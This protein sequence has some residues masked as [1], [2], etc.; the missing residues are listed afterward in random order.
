MKRFY[1]I[2]TGRNVFINTVL[3]VVLVL[4]LSITVHAEEKPSWAYNAKSYVYQNGIGGLTRVF[5]DNVHYNENPVIYV[6]EYDGSFTL[7][8]KR[9]IPRELPL[10]GGFYAGAEYNYLFFGQTNK[11]ED[12]NAEVIRVVKYSKS[13]ERLGHASVLGANTTEPFRSGS[14]RC[15]EAGGMLY[16]HTC[17]QMYKSNDGLNH[18]ANMTF[19]VRVGDMAV[20]SVRAGISYANTGYV[21]HSFDQYILADKEGNIVTLDLGDAYPRAITL[22][23]FN[24]MAGSEKLGTATCSVILKIDGKIGDNNTGVSIGGFAETDTGYITAYNYKNGTG[25]SF[26]LAYTS[27]SDLSTKITPLSESLPTIKAPALAPMGTSGGYVFWK[28]P[29]NG[30]VQYYALY[31]AD[32]SIGEIHATDAFVWTSD[33]G[34]SYRNASF[35]QPAL[36]NGKIV[37]SVCRGEAVPMSFSEY[38]NKTVV[39]Y[40]LDETGIQTISLSAE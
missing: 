22:S 10:Y 24:G 14:C 17:H 4:S 31:Y 6:E 3:C 37:W 1:S 34:Y 20:T 18:Q 26:Y 19:I 38:N 8:A 28:D 21:S 25:R 29:R 13:W 39:F 30:A 2:A 33:G 12:N 23:R 15:V 27:K 11:S 16:V 36:C 7:Q 9:D 40:M 35:S 5:I 32:G